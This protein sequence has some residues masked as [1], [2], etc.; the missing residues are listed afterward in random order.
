MVNVR[1]NHGFSCKWS[2]G[3]TWRHNYLKDLVYHGL[4]HAGLTS[5]KEPAR[6]FRTDC[7]RSDGLTNVPWL[8][9]KPAVWDIIV[10]DTL[11]DFCLSFMTM[12]DATAAELAATRK[13]V[14]IAELSTMHHFFLLPS[15]H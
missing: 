7:K 5:T 11:A 9:N 12:I 4:L 15:S 1:S 6:L 14:K 13:E 2:A 10:A 3:R 8:A